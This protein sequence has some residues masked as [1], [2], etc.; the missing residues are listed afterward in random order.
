MVCGA[1]CLCIRQTATFEPATASSAPSPCSALMS[2]TM[3]APALMAARITSVLQV[4]TD[5][6]TLPPC[7]ASM[8][9]ST[10]RSSSSIPTDCAPG[11]DDSPPISRMSAPSSSSRKACAIPAAVD[12]WR[13]PSENESGVTL[14]MPMINGRLRGRVKRPQTNIGNRLECVG[15]ARFFVPTW[16]TKL[17]SAWAQKT[18]PTLPVYFII[19]AP[20]R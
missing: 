9:G 4:S 2:L 11:R 10:R 14:T 7:N 18:V 5:T 19:P 8:I 20:G 13:P 12:A 17:I 3:A 1:P 15:W 6:G 16:R